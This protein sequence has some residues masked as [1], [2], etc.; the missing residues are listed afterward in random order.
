MIAQGS[1][2]TASGISR[3]ARLDQSLGIQSDDDVWARW[4]DKEF[5]LRREGN[6]GW[7]ETKLPT[8]EGMMQ[9]EDK[10]RL[11]YPAKQFCKDLDAIIA[12]KH[13]MTRRQWLSLL[14]S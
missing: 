11:S 2:D 10:R 12:A 9:D 1:P 14:E 6:P 13:L 4:L 3:W 7:S 5:E 8:L